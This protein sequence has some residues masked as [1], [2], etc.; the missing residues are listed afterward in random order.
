M[1][2]SLSES[3]LC[4]TSAKL[5]MPP[6]KATKKVKTQKKE[7]LFHPLSRKADQ[8]IRA[9]HRQSKLA[10]LT[11]ARHKKH[12][13]QG[14]YLYDPIKCKRC[15]DSSSPV[16]IFNFFY[17]CLPPDGTASLPLSVLHVLVRDVWLARYDSE[18]EEEKKSRRKGRPKSVR[19]QKIEELKL[20]EAEE[21]R[22]GLG[23]SPSLSMPTC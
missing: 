3:Y 1:E 11:K 13:E 4:P 21:Y 22:T 14:S 18:L 2:I 16:D 23:T 7:K 15:F 8:L 20:R 9:Q 19:E 5:T 12:G 6:P 17:Q 10:E